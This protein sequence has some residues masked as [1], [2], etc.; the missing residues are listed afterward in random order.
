MN[1]SLELPISKETI[2]F[3]ES[4][5]LLFINGEWRES[6]SGETIPVID[7]AT[8]K[9]I[10]EV[11]S[12]TKDDIDQAVKSARDALTGEW[13]KIPSHDRAQILHRLSDEIEANF[14]TLS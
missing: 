1:N 8:E 6:S 13:S 9:K 5:H 4:K 10:A 12:G 11:Q 3:L 2:K 7:P 14:S